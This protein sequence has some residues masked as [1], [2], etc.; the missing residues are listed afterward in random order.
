M[1]I[2]RE[3]LRL[4]TLF[5]RLETVRLNTL[6]IRRETVRLNTLFIRRETVRLN[7][8]F[9]RL[10]TVRLNTLFIH[11]ELDGCRLRLYVRRALKNLLFVWTFQDI[12]QQACIYLTF[13]N[14]LPFPLNTWKTVRNFETGCI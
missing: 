10:E 3:T 2:R 4:N 1:F 11:L 12:S 6:F 14:S 7:T 9:I 8:L 5:I 13:K